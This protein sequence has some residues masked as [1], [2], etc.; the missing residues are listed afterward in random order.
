M[1][2]KKITCPIYCDWKITLFYGNSKELEKEVTKFNLKPTGWGGKT[3]THKRNA[4]TVIFL[5]NEREELEITST[6]VHEIRHVVDKMMERLE[7]KDTE[8][9]AYLS[10]WIWKNFY[11]VIMSDE[12]VKE[13]R[14]K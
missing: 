10:G 12:K 14:E 3:G 8:A 11:P 13:I 1:K 7:I 5:K 4:E 9:A 6:L 2:K